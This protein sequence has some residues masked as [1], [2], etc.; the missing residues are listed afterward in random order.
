MEK[1]IT[2]SIEEFSEKLEELTNGGV[3]IIFDQDGWSYGSTEEYGDVSESELYELLE[4]D[5]DIII[6]RIRIDL[7]AGEV[8]I[9]LK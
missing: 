4:E 1:C 3:C 6:D 2:S 5:L 7:N 9:I 8:I